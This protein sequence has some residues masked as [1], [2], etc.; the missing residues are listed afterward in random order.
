MQTKLKPDRL[1]GI[2]IDEYGIHNTNSFLWKNKIERLVK[3]RTFLPSVI[4]F[5]LLKKVMKMN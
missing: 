3:K 4:S 5:C 2:P 1:L